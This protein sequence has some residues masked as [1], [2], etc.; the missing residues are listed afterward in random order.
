MKNSK[1]KII[2]IFCAFSLLGVLATSVNAMENKS[3]V[4]NFK[5]DFET[6]DDK[7]FDYFL[8]RGMKDVLDESYDFEMNKNS[9]SKNN[10]AKVV[11][12]NNKKNDNELNKNYDDM[13]EDNKEDDKEIEDDK[14]FDYFLG[15]GMKDV[16]DESYDFETFS[17]RIFDGGELFKEKDEKMKDVPN[18]I[19]T[20]YLNNLNNNINL[21][22]VVDFKPEEYLNNLNNNFESSNKNNSLYNRENFNKSDIMQNKGDVNIDDINNKLIDYKKKFENLSRALKD[23]ICSETY[24]KI[25][26]LS[27]EY[28]DLRYNY[29]KF[30]S[31]NN[32]LVDQKDKNSIQQMINGIYNKIN[33]IYL[34]VDFKYFEKEF[35]KILNYFDYVISLKNGLDIK[36]FDH[37]KC[38]Y[39]VLYSKYKQY[40]KGSYELIGKYKK[41]SSLKKNIYKIIELK[42]NIFIIID[43]AAR[44]IETIEKTILEKKS[45]GIDEI[46]FNKNLNYINNSS[47]IETN[48]ISYRNNF[49]D[50]LTYCDDILSSKT[51][52]DREN[53]NDKK[54]YFNKLYYDYMKYFKNN[55]NT[56]CGYKEFADLKFKIFKIIDDVRTKINKIF[57][58]HVAIKKEINEKNQSFH[59]NHYIE[60]QND[61]YKYSFEY[62][63]GNN[64]SYSLNKE[65]IYKFNEG[66]RK[67]KK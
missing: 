16:L 52:F 56:I 41:Y 31:V 21:E 24:D 50:I 64:Y 30:L 58:E 57:R 65:G 11:D 28:S 3:G 59:K 23:M 49:N 8:G 7:N 5:E 63:D 55:R 53:F 13:D 67:K 37:V 46:N 44:K 34:S 48:L 62:N 14:N 4:E 1:F 43:D 2:S 22:N 15:R 47:D 40:V 25:K 20:K 19:P 36:V 33:V 10:E 18:Y 26:S 60:K 9:V 6:E 45:S 42:K 38:C 51:K 17:N 29:Y 61:D 39:N 12:V 66:K 54:H 32:S 35:Q 27:K